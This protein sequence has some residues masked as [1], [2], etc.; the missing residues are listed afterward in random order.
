MGM[1]GRIVNSVMALAS[2][3]DELRKL[4]ESLED[5]DQ[6]KSVAKALSGP[7]P[8]LAIKTLSRAMDLD[9]TALRLRAIEM[10]E[11][12]GRSE[13]ARSESVD[14]LIQM[15]RTDKDWGVRRQST[16]ALGNLKDEKAIPALIQGL[17]DVDPRVHE[18]AIT[19]IRKMGK[20]A[21]AYLQLELANV[22]T[23][24]LKWRCIEVL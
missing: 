6:R 8:K 2:R 18:A 22:N 24:L 21:L 23:P 16:A 11:I 19:S 5:P 12:I 1:R 7:N 15:A 13:K 4:L 17:I 20:K 14:L 3:Q 10:I 9:N